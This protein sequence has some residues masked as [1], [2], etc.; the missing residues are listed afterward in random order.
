MG[1]AFNEGTKRLKIVKRLETLLKQK[2]KSKKQT[3]NLIGVFDIYHSR[4]I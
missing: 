2:V 3:S 4:S 1:G